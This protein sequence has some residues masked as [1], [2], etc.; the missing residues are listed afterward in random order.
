[1][2]KG[3]RAELSGPLG[4][5]WTD[6]LSAGRQLAALVGG[7]VGVAPLGALADELPDGSFDFYAGF[8]T[9]FE[10]AVEEAALIGQGF[11]RSNN[12]II[13]TEDGTAAKDSEP[14]DITGKIFR[15]GRIPDFLEPQKYRAVCACGPEPMLKAV[16]AQ[17]KAA[18]V[19]CFV[20][21]ERRMACGVGACLG[22]TVPTIH[23]NRRCCAD[24]PIFPAEEVFF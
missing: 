10:N 7:G 16:A 24:G 4:N 23:G 2:R 19:P 3:E 6:F 18:K 20:S 5:A 13:A 1:M 9:G 21:L 17:C 8:K 12:M 15:K 22:C 11:F 14:G